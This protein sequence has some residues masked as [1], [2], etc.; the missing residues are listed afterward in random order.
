VLQKNF[1][2]SQFASAGL[3]TRKRSWWQFW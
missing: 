3:T 1:P 2:N